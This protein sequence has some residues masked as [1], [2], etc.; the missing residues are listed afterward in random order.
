MIVPH[1]EEASLVRWVFNQYLEGVS[2]PAIAEQLALSPLSPTGQVLRGTRTWVCRILDNAKYTVTESHPA[3]I[4]T[5]IFAK[6]P[7]QAE[8]EAKREPEP[9][10]PGGEKQLELCGLP[11]SSPTGY[12]PFSAGHG[13]ALPPLR[14]VHHSSGRWGITPAD[15]ERC[16]PPSGYT[17]PAP[18]RRHSTFP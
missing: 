8:S 1:G 14:Y 11:P 18:S 7:E 12:P 13:M 10:P 3:I 6:T 5:E 15:C 2:I 17:A 16:K 4:E 9:H